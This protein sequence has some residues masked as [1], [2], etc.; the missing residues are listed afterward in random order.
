[1]SLVNHAINE[2]NIA[3]PENEPMQD[4]IKENILELIKVFSEQGHSGSSAPYVLEYFNKLARFEPINPLTGEDDEWADRGNGLF[5][6]IRCSEV[7]KNG[8]NGQAYWINGNIFR[9]QDGVTFTSNN[10]SVPVT[11]PWVRP[12]SNIV[13]VFEHPEAE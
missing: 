9:N 10:S 7:F 11:F 1:M 4:A 5:Q 2:M 13:D 6:N 12:E 8:K 3:W